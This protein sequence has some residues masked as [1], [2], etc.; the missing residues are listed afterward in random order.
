M[1]P[2]MIRS[3]LQSKLAFLKQNYLTWQNNFLTV[4]HSIDD[5][6]A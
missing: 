5:T 2:A 1:A 3:E 6:S 4:F